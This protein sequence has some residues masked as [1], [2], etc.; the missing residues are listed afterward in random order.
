MSWFQLDPESI[1]TRAQ[2]NGTPSDVPSLKASLMRG[3]IGFTFVSVAGFAPW[4]F[5]G[6]WFSRRIG[7]AGLYAVCAVIFIG[8]SGLV[9]HRLIIGRGSL[10]R[11][12]K[13]FGIAFTAYSVAWIVGWMSLRGHAGS[14]VGLLA[15]TA[16]MSW[17]LTR[18]FDA[19]DAT[20]KVIAAL[21]VLNALGYFI[22]GWVEGNVMAMKEFSLF[23]VALERRTQRLIA[24]L[25]WGVFYGIGLGAGLGLAFYNCQ[26]AARALLLNRKSG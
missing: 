7:E 26:A 25:L 6:R 16:V 11:F 12:Y 8:L 2:T 9:L 19:V 22:G 4:A 21:F 23:G 1:A 13:L 5:A 20:W 15:G 18:A 24:M 3:I 14:V 10:I 17:L